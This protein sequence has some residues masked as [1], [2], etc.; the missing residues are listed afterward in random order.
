MPKAVQHLRGHWLKEFPQH[1][2]IQKLVFFFF[3]SKAL[4][5]PSQRSFVNQTVLK[6]LNPFC[7]GLSF[8][9]CLPSSHC[10]DAA[11]PLG[12]CSYQHPTF[13]HQN[14]CLLPIPEKYITPNKSGRIISVY[15]LVITN[16]MMYGVLTAYQAWCLSLGMLRVLLQPHMD[17]G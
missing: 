13:S 10:K 8:S 6:V 16:G 12:F 11:I 5:S 17:V 7:A 14:V 1:S 4:V 3:P 2:T 15:G 9:F